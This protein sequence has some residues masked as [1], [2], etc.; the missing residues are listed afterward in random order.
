MLFSA[1]FYKELNMKNPLNSQKILDLLF[2]R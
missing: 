1:F 2:S